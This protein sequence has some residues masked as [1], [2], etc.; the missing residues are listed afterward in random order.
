MRHSLFLLLCILTLGVFGQKSKTVQY[1]NTYAIKT[2]TGTKKVQLICLIPQ[3]IEGVQQVDTLIYSIPPSRTFDQE[4]DRFV[5]FNVDAITGDFVIQIL[6]QLQLKSNDF[7]NKTNQAKTEDL[8]PYLAAEKFIESEQEPLIQQA[9]ALKKKSDL[10]TVQSI[11]SFVRKTMTYSG[12]NPKDLG[13]LAALEAKQ[14]D[15][16][17]FADL[18][19]ALCRANQIP[20]RVI[21]GYKTESISMP[22]HNWAEVYLPELGWRVVDPTV[23]SFD[24]LDNA[25]VKLSSNRT[26]NTFKGYHYWYY[27]YWGDPVVIKE[28]VRT[29]AGR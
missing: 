24:Q 1:S 29:R 12:Y 26:N 16:T 6:A 25:Y 4:G 28:T 7:S 19:V 27:T 8:S 13:A 20:A 17:E 15:C 22:Q 21:E 18:F 23:S 10:K 2:Q 3:N 14:G 5:E 9:L 11:Y